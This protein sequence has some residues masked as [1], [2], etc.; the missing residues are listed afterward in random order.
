VGVKND[1]LVGV[2]KE[3]DFLCCHLDGPVVNV[4]HCLDGLFDLL[5]Q[6][7]NLRVSDLDRRQLLCLREQLLFI[8]FE[9]VKFV[10]YVRAFDL[11]STQNFNFASDLAHVLL[12]K[13]D[14]ALVLFKVFLFTINARFLKFQ[15]VGVSQFNF[16]LFHQHLLHDSLEVVVDLLHCFDFAPLYFLGQLVALL[17]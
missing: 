17:D 7:F 1:Y 16:S 2:A 12:T 3:A 15:G 11:F 8:P 10:A 6:K 9:V 13:M 14:Q 5:G 4:R